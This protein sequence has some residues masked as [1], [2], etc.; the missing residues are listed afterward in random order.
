MSTAAHELNIPRKTFAYRLKK[1]ARRNKGAFA[2]VTVI[3]VLLV[4][5]VAGTSIGL[6]R[7]LR[8]EAEARRQ[9]EI[10][11]AVN[12]FLND[13]LLASVAPENLGREVTVR[14]VLDASAEKIEGR[15][16]DQPLVEAE[17]RQTIGDT[18]EYGFHHIAFLIGV[19]RVLDVQV[20]SAVHDVGG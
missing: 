3:A 9:A 14:D 19:V 7:S 20:V 16:P 1:L 15:F 10:A 13:D 11:R 17:I 5:G 4:A 8:A 6:A 18:Y 2:A 12:E